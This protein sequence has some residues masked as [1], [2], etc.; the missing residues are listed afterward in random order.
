MDR[1]LGR[2]PILWWAGRGRRALEVDDEH[3]H[4]TNTRR[5][6][7]YNTLFVHKTPGHALAEV[8]RVLHR[9]P[10]LLG[11]RRPLQLEVVKDLRCDGRG[12]VIIDRSIVEYV[13]VYRTV[14]SIGPSFVGGVRVPCVRVLPWHRIGSSRSNDRT[15]QHN[16]RHQDSFH[17]YNV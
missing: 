11:E 16:H 17:M 2:E 3:R 8:L 13:I 5:A 1:R 6:H 9:A 4:H 7:T 12:V 14:G 10:P 15:N